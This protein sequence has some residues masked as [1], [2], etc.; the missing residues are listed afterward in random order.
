MNIKLAITGR[1][2]YCFC[3]RVALSVKN[4]EK[5]PVE[6]E[7]DWLTDKEVISLVR[8]IKTGS[9]RALAGE[10]QL[11]EREYALVSDRKKDKKEVEAP[12]VVTEVKE[13]EKP[14]EIVEKVTEKEVVVEEVK[15]EVESEPKA[16]EAPVVEKTPAKTP[17]RRTS[18]KK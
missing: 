5:N 4:T 18:T 10:K 7:L 13:E 11:F 17:T 15:E 16:E 12:V 14:A 3:G 1:L 9:I 6:V 8:A 2:S